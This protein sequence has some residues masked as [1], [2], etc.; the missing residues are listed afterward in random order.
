MADNDVE[1]TLVYFGN[2]NTEKYTKWFQQEKAIT[3]V[4][5][6]SVELRDGVVYDE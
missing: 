3:L 6:D 5:F 2:G 4:F 1:E